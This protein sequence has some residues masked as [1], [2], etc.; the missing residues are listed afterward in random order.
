MAKK[1]LISVKDMK[2]QPIG[3][4]KAYIDEKIGDMINY[5]ILL[6]GLLY[7]RNNI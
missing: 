1:H 4:A 2:N 6:K 5:L 7:R 3:H